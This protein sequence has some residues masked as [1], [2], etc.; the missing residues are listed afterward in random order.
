MQYYKKYYLAR[1]CSGC[2]RV[3]HFVGGLEQKNELEKQF[4][5]SAPRLDDDA[6]RHVRGL[7]IF[8]AQLQL[9]G[10]AHV[11]QTLQLHNLMSE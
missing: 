7:R 4:V 3:D 11:V 1:F 10:R 6:R 5:E 2:E 8:A 9:H